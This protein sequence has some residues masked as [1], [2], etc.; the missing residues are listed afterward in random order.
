MENKDYNRPI[1]IVIPNWNG[2]KFLKTCLD[3]LKRQTFKDFEVI[4]VDNG[5]TDESLEFLRENYPEVNVIGLSSNRGFS[6]AVNEGIK[7]SA[8]EF[9]ALLNNDTEVDP[10]WLEELHR[11]LVDNPS[12]GSCAPKILFFHERDTI[13]SVGI[14][15]HRDGTASDRGRGAKDQRQYDEM[16]EVFGA[17]GAAA[18]Y[19]KSMFDRIGLLDEDFFAFYEDVDLSF[20]AQLAGYKCVY[21]PKAI[22]YHVAGGTVSRE[23]PRNRYLCDRNLIRVLIKNLPDSL[24]I[25]Y[26]P[27]IAFYQVA[28]SIYLFKKG[29]VFGCSSLF[30]KAMGLCSF[31]QLL[32]TRRAIQQQRKVTTEYIDSILT[33][34]TALQ[35]SLARRTR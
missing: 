34:S 24:I 32:G 15:Y 5:S 26:F 31:F 30:G 7:R 27:S 6:A 12:A 13:A 11:G 21:Q 25:R 3:S 28:S 17:S 22:V 35:I 9:I 4:V 23:K 19:R 1:S 10:R 16:C 8:G 20:R 2:K 14:Q 29:F 18:L 33:K